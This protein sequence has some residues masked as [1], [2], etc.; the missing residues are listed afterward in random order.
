MLGITGGRIVAYLPADDEH[1]DGIQP[2]AQNAR[3]G[4]CSAGACRHA[5]ERG[6]VVEA[7][8]SLRGDRRG[9]FVMIIVA[10]EACL[11]AERIVEMH[12]TPADYGK[13]ICNSV[14]DEEVRYIVG[15]ANFHERF[16]LYCNN[17]LH[18]IMI[19]PPC[20]VFGK[21][22]NSRPF[23]RKGGRGDLS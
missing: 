9:L 3:N 14:I 21:Q 23:R 8:I 7:S 11:V 20:Q 10:F 12:G 2:G 13:A 15:E 1:G 5:D 6:T 17:K 19:F 4:V 22:K 18:F 16:S